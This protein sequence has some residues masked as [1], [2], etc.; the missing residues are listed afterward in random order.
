MAGTRALQ[1]AT[2]VLLSWSGGKDSAWALHA[3]RGN[4]VW[5][6]RGLLT[7]V[8]SRDGRVNVHG[9]RHDVLQAQA[10]A[11]GLP[12]LEARIEPGAC[13]VDY[14]A[15]LA[16]ALHHARQ[17]WPGLVHIAF[18]DLY[19]ADVRAYR[20]ALCARLGW[21]PLFPLFGSD[22]AT[23]ARAMLDAGLRARLCCVDTSQLEAGFAGR[24]FDA[25]LLQ[26]LPPG[27]D[28]CG[29][30]GEFHT[31]VWD[32]PG[33]AAPLRLVDAGRVGEGRF[34]FRDLELEATMP[35]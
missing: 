20:E 18:G 21:T 34:V 27:I 17:R 14:E 35:A 19:L 3:L 10:S 29:E 24:E 22:T 8:S 9:V 25:R 30:R 5:Q 13:N 31:C 15:A 12:L 7:S 33:F 32:G 26:Q 2:P 6:V 11:L 16:G 4:P 28:P 23:L 1:G